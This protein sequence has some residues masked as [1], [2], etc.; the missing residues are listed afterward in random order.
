MVTLAINQRSLVK[1]YNI[2]RPLEPSSYE[3]QLIQTQPV[4]TY[5]TFFPS[6]DYVLFLCRIQEDSVNVGER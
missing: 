4:D 6:F 2:T 1:S 5:L 3:N